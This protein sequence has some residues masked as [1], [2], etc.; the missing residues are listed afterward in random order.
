MT[1]PLLFRT[2]VGEY[3]QDYDVYGG[4][5]VEVELDILT[6]TFLIRRVDAIEDCGQSMSPYVDLGQVEGA[7]A[8]SMGLFT[9]EELKYDPTTGQKITAGTW[10]LCFL[11]FLLFWIGLPT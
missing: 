1:F 3:P 9:C 4:A 10:V 2:K 5:V 8:L 6:G 11:K 7:L